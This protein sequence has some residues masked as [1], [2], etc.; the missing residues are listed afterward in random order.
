MNS[1]L[2]RRCVYEQRYRR[3]KAFMNGV[4]ER[5]KTAFQNTLFQLAG[6]FR[7]RVAFQNVNKSGVSGREVITSVMVV[8]H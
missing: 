4:L 1:I 3:C 5:F 8:S 6:R 2:E 7:I